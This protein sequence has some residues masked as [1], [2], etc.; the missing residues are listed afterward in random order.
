MDVGAGHVSVGDGHAFVRGDVDVFQGEVFNWRFGQADDYGGGAA[1]D[2]L[3]VLDGDVVE[4]GRKARDGR[5][6]D[7]AFMVMSLKLML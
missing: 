2:R 1:L 4:E 5:C 3:N 6:G 7:V